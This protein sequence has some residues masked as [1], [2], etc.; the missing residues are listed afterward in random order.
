MI[1][2]FVFVFMFVFDLCFVM[3]W[4]ATH[5]VHPRTHTWTHRRLT[6][7]GGKLVSVHRDAP[8]RGWWT[9]GAKFGRGWRMAYVQVDLWGVIQKC[10]AATSACCAICHREETRVQSEQKE[11]KREGKKRIFDK[12]CYCL[13]CNDIMRLN[14]VSYIVIAYLNAQFLAVHVEVVVRSYICNEKWEKLFL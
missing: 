6:I 1:L 5:G 7:H 10:K 11:E 9:L 3:P 2:V 12:K 4:A 14:V 13:S 8:S